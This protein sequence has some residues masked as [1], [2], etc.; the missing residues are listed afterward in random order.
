V[1]VAKLMI[2]CVGKN[3][4]SL[5]NAE[6][7]NVVGISSKTGFSTTRAYPGPSGSR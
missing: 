2:V 7:A 5:T 6:T 1:N 3:A 4:T